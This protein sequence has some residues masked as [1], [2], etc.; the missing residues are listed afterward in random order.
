MATPNSHSWK[1]SYEQTYTRC[2]RAGHRAR[3]RGA[4][5]GCNRNGVPGAQDP[6]LGHRQV[7]AW[8]SGIWF[9]D[10]QTPTGSLLG[11]SERLHDQVPGRADRDSDRDRFSNRDH[12]AAGSVQDFAPQRFVSRD[13]VP[14]VAFPAPGVWH[15]RRSC[16][17][18]HCRSDRHDSLPAA[19]R[20]RGPKACGHDGGTRGLADRG[21]VRAGV[22]RRHPDVGHPRS[23]QAAGQVP[24]HG[25]LASA[26]C[27]GE[28]P[29]E[30]HGRGRP[31]EPGEPAGH[32]SFLRR[33]PGG[34]GECPGRAGGAPLHDAALGSSPGN[35]RG[36]DCLARGLR[37]P[38]SE[39]SGRGRH[40]P[41][42]L[43][44]PVTDRE[45]SEG[46]DHQ[47]R[48]GVTGLGDLE[49]R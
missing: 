33:L 11:A 7:V 6:H 37:H 29:G 5:I 14:H 45:I 26:A 43:L 13:Q 24:S 49:A 48:E 17:G 41:Q 2:P 10:D 44:D 39:R 28:S 42:I 40:R 4:G 18:Q 38:A 30:G 27:R 3:C 36:A 9:P 23:V 32:G 1:L 47:T 12:R 46:S 15:G 34:A 21:R 22:H 35:H 31:H 19:A 16:L 25:S 20:S 8:R